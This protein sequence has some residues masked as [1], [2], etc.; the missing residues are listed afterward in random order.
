MVLEHLLLLDPT[1]EQPVLAISY[2]C[3][4]VGS[5]TSQEQTDLPV[6]VLEPLAPLAVSVYPVLVIT[7]A[8][9]AL[10]RTIPLAVAVVLVPLVPMP[11]QVVSVVLAVQG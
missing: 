11:R 9:L 7:A 4:V 8:M 1:E 5:V 6:V 3:K 10:L 2:S